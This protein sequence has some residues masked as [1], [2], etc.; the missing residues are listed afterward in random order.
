MSVPK[1][2]QKYNTK[3][4]K[5]FEGKLTAPIAK[6]LLAQN[7]PGNYK[8]RSAQNEELFA[9]IMLCDGWHDYNGDTIAISVSEWLLNG[10]T[11]CGATIRADEVQPGIEV[12][13]LFACEI[14]DDA[15]PTIDVGRVR[16]PAHIVA[17]A[18]TEA[19]APTYYGAALRIVHCYVNN[20]LSSITEPRTLQKCTI[21]EL[22]ELDYPGMDAS[23]KKQMR[24]HRW[25]FFS[26]YPARLAIAMHW[27][28]AQKHEGKADEFFNR[29]Y[30]NDCVGTGN[31]L[32]TLRMR[33]ERTP[34]TNMEGKVAETIIAW[35]DWSR[36]RARRTINWKVSDG[37]P[38]IVGDES[39]I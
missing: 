3:N 27:L 18:D 20:N 30:A 38:E 7:F 35:N 31:A 33:I 25:S 24:F 22:M 4:V 19:H 12:S 9:S 6:Q 17:M 34:P 36:N 26:V 2:L 10:Q 21:P 1:I 13:A 23:V 39:T 11:R 37:I 14:P 16:T 28:F 15:F 32:H 8:R 5:V 29:L